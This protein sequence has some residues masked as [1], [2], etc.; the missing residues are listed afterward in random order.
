MAALLFL[1]GGVAAGLYT[2]GLAHLAAG[3]TSR[4]LAAANAAFVLTYSIGMLMGPPVAGLGLDIWNP[5]G[6]TV[7]LAVFA[8]AYA[9]LVAASLARARPC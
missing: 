3:H 2:V 6:F 4:T 8:F 9:A 7:T 5:H 1:W